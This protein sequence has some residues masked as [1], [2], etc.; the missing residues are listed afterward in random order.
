MASDASPVANSG[1]VRRSSGPARP[2]IYE[3]RVVGRGQTPRADAGKGVSPLGS[4]ISR[5][6]VVNNAV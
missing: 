1:A 6:T 5:Q 4:A 3:H 2:L